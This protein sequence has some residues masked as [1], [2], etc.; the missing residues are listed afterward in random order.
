MGLECGGAVFLAWVRAR[1]LARALAGA[2]RWAVAWG[3][4]WDKKGQLGCAW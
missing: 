3:L 4:V 2:S 1:A